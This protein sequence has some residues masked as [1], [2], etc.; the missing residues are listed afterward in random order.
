MTTKYSVYRAD[1]HGQVHAPVHF[2]YYT[3]AKQF[4]I[5]MVTQLL[6]DEGLTL[7]VSA[8]FDDGGR[9]VEV[10]RGV[11]YIGRLRLKVLGVD[12]EQ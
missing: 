12:N 2:R 1:E 3:Q 5:S 4:F 6:Q 7:G 11:Q 9:L 10:H 8:Q